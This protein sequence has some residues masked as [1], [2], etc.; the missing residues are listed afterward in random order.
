MEV[1]FVPSSH[2]PYANVA[3]TQAQFR[4]V[5]LPPV[6]DLPLFFPSSILAS[7]S[8]HG[9]ALTRPTN[10]RREGDLVLVLIF[11]RGRERGA[12]SGK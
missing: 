5:S 9:L 6:S 2:Q 4:Y 1:Y 12:T 11:G 8:F 10:T 3:A 7:C